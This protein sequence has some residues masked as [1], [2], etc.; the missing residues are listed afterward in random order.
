MIAAIQ[1]VTAKEGSIM[2][3]NPLIPA[4]LVL[5]SLALVGPAAA[6][7]VTI[8]VDDVKWSP[9]PAAFPKGAQITVLSGDPSKEGPYVLRLKF[10]AGYKVA[11]HNHPND[12][13][14]TVV[15]GALRFGHG[16]KLDEQK[17]TLLKAGSYVMTPK[18]M[19]HYVVIGEDTV[20]QIHAIGPS[21]IT[22]VNP[23]DDP[24]RSN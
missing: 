5:G 16:D 22:Y 11:A 9:A 15:S 2:S 7:H 24:R 10:P 18:G 21:G 17:G 1:S 4:L 8:A 6:Q 12:E 23:A 13:N 19:N 14:L 3:R 20:V